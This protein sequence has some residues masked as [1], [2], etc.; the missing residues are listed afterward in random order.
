MTSALALLAGVLLAL[1]GACV[2][3]LAWLI[4]ATCIVV[5]CALSGLWRHPWP[6]R[7]ALLMFGMVFAAHAVLRWQSLLLPGPA[8]D[9]RMLLEG[10][11]ITVPSRS[12]AEL[13]F[14]AEVI[15]VDGQARDRPRDSR[16]RRARLVW[17]DP[18]FVPRVGE[19]WRWL[20]RQA[21]YVETR[22]FAG[23]AAERG[24][25][26]D[27]VQLRARVL[28]A[29]LNER[30]ALAGSSLDG[31]RARIAARIAAAISDP[32]AAALLAALAVG[33]TDRLSLD[34]WRVFNA[35]GTT[36]LVAISGLHVTL[37]AMFAFMAARFAWRWLP[38]A[39][40]FEREPFAW[41]LGIVSA[42]AYALLAGLS[43]PTQRT[44]IMLCAFGFVRVMAR[45]AGAARTWSL[46]LVVV[47]VLDPMAPLAAGFWL[48]F[49]AVGVI[50]LCTATRIEP[51]DRAPGA[52][53]WAAVRLQLAITLA[54]APL[55]FALLDNV[56]LAG[57][58]GN[59]A[60]IPLVSFVLVPLVLAGAVTVLIAPGLGALFFGLAEAVYRWCWPGL[61]W[62]ADSQLAQ[63]R[64]VPDAWWFLLAVPGA[65]I[66]LCR[67]PWP[68]RL[69]GLV[70]V[71]P[72]VFA[73]PRSPE[74]GTAFV[75][76]FDAGRGTM[77]LIV[78]RSR[79]VLFDTGDSWNTRG[80]RLRQLALPALDAL[81][82]RKVD[83]LVI[84]RLDPDR[85]RGAA[86]LA[87][88]RGVGRIVVGGGWPAARLPAGTCADERFRWDG[89]DFSLHAAGPGRR[90]CVLR[91]SVGDHA[92][93]F[94]G[95]LDA[96]SER[97]LA[98][99]W[100]AG[101]ANDVVLMSRGA[102][103]TVSQAEWI[104]ASGARLAIAAGGIAHSRSRAAVL[105]RWRA[106]GVR[107][108]DTRSEGAIE[109]GLGTQ[110]IVV[111]GMART[112]RY[113]FAWRR[114]P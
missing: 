11:V 94:P 5:C 63:W 32:D 26:R 52:R 23:S 1:A 45:H 74:S 42:G 12:G 91:V 29:A 65:F 84:P 100:P 48:S 68:L 78:T 72:L 18:L 46:A 110:G 27:G 38:V 88:E 66:L 93:L 109:I 108:L 80:A 44:W 43:V 60:A 90:F 51:P 71:L 30:L 77:A 106:A 31:V 103:A 28:P 49:V 96:A 13:Q 25:F 111:T 4:T 89:V 41:L 36:H 58:W 10:R 70:A 40:R 76:V 114:L 87:L 67:W 104:G 15:I 53:L 112:S 98:Q 79:T 83:L 50:L 61:V 81:G 39:R 82:A 62:T 69:T 85:A 75:R 17:R 47:L 35:T 22:N 14:D 21:P 101:I 97:V 20:V 8:A 59:L 113:P 37:F 2:P 16:P 7:M 107:V 86:L 73:L 6:R 64:A 9:S 99:R 33:F 105:A 57:I 55:T 56:P 19:H 24:A 92:L 34:Q 102:S 95:E 3:S 54:L